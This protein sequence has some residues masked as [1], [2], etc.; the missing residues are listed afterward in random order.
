MF[1]LA[2]IDPLQDRALQQLNGVSPMDTT[3]R[4]IRRLFTKSLAESFSLTGLGAKR[5]KTKISFKDHVVSVSVLG[6][7][8][9]NVNTHYHY[10]YFGYES[11]FLASP[12]P[13]HGGSGRRNELLKFINVSSS[14]LEFFFQIQPRPT[15]GVSK[16]YRGICGITS[17]KLVTLSNR[18]RLEERVCHSNILWK[19]VSLMSLKSIK[20]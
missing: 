8:P 14:T 12:L 11:I 19:F 6:E 13:L 15:E 20:C 10:I 16:R 2:I 17:W 18:N 9:Y 1:R 3:R 4:I 5:Q 7:L